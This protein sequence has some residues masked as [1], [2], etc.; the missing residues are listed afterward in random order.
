MLT[1]FTE[2][3]EK[4]KEENDQTKERANHSTAIETTTEIEHSSATN[5]TKEKGKA[6]KKAKDEAQVEAET[7]R[8]LKPVATAAFQDTMPETVE[9]DKTMR[10]KS[11]RKHRTNKAKKSETTF[12]SWMN[13]TC[14]LHNTLPM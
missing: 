12:R 2:G 3:G 4:A 11:K 7:D 1:V 10:S 5:P 13:S 9:E 8:I 6:D 14:N